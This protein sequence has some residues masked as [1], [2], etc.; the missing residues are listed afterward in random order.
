MCLSIRL[1]TIETSSITI[2]FKFD[3]FVLIALFLSSD[4]G[5]KC[6][7]KT[8]LAIAKPELMVFPPMFIAATPAGASRNIDGLSGSSGPCLKVLVTV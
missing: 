2:N 8:F 6:S 7:P 1:E 5:L 4:K 3:N